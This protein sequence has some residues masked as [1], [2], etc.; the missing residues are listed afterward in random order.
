SFGALELSHF[1]SH[2]CTPLRSYRESNKEVLKSAI[3][4]P[5]FISSFSSLQQTH[6]F[7][8][9]NISFMACNNKTA[10]LTLFLLVILLIQQYFGLTAGSR[11]R[12]LHAP[13]MAASSLVMPK[14]PSGSMEIS[15]TVNPYKKME[16]DAFR[17]TQPGPS[18]G[19]GHYAPPKAP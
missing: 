9:Y 2:L 19:V 4:E 6:F 12:E 16:E 1:A 13:V 8:R 5:K 3:Q 14:P 15:F 10:T 11:L 17:P 7:G 18:P